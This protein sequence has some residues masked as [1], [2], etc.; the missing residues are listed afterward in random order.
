MVMRGLWRQIKPLALHLPARI[1]DDGIGEGRQDLGGDA[2]MDAAELGRP[3]GRGRLG[4]C[5]STNARK[6]RIAGSLRAVMTALGQSRQPQKGCAQGEPAS[7]K[8]LLWKPAQ[9]ASQT[10]CS[11]SSNGPT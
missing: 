8:G 11:P 9:A 6:A 2:G 1:G 7:A 4:L 5:S 3:V 10:S